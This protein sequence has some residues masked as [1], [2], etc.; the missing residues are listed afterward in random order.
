MGLNSSEI[1]F[2]KLEACEIYNLPAVKIT[3]FAVK[4]DAIDFTEEVEE[5]D[6]SQELEEMASEIEEINT[7][8]ELNAIF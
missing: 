7:P 6:M 4:E 1:H 2:F 3:D 8:E 5:M